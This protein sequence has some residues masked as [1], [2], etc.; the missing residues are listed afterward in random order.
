[1]QYEVDQSLIPI[2]SDELDEGLGLELLPSFIRSQS[3]LCECIVE[4]F[5]S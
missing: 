4:V 1:M 2:L 3:I 5:E